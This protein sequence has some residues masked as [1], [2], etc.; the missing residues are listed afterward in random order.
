[1][2]SVTLMAAAAAALATLAGV[3]L[4]QPPAPRPSAAPSPVQR[5]EAVFKARCASCHDPAIE[6]APSR[7]DLANYLSE[8]LKKALTRGVMRDMAAGLSEADI[9]NVSWYLSG[10]QIRPVGDVSREDQNRCPASDRFSPAGP[11]WN[12]WSPD[13]VQSRHQK[14]G[15]IAAADVPKLK[16]KWAFAIEGG[17]YGQPTIFGN[18]LY[19]VSSSGRAYAL[20]AATGCVAWT[21]T[22]EF[23]MRT[24]PVVSKNRAAPSG[25]A[26]Y[27]GDY[28]KV[29]YAADAGSGKILWKLKVDPL[30][31]AVLTGGFVSNAG[32]L[33]VPLSTWE[34]AAATNGAYECC[35][36]R[37]AVIAIDEATGKQLW[38]T[39]TIAETAKPYRKNAAGTQMWGPAGA[40]IWA[41]PTLDLKR[42]LIYVATGD[43][44]TDLDDGGASDAVMA[45]DL[46]T[47]AVRWKHQ[48]TP[49]DNFISACGPSRR[50]ENCPTKVGPDVDFGASPILRTVDGKDVLLAGQ[51]SGVVYGMDPATGTVL[52]QRKVSAGS[53]GGGIIWGMAADDRTVYAAAADRQGG[54]NA[55]D[56]A[57]GELRW[58]VKID[59][60]PRCGWQGRC[61]GGYA[62]PPT[63]IPGVVLSAAADGHLRA[64]DVAT[65]QKVWDFD[66]AGQTYKTVNGVDKQRGG[67]IESYGP[68]IADGR[69]YVISGYNGAG[70]GGWSDN[71]LLAFTKDGK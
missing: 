18:R 71:V 64:F 19:V 62:S 17:R 70:G 30:P 11:S 1:V 52:W 68:T 53:A 48:V 39:Y 4:A 56:I 2:K 61:S 5:G 47:G 60:Q 26:V 7:T 49:G 15:G 23:G 12:G 8:T 3:A 40:A 32:V 44:Y 29:V 35:R 22:S 13:L 63:V 24:A 27:F 50:A 51:K 31:R 28:D 69:L 38:K 58:S 55:L 43:S 16:V 21:Y 9:D 59:P 67:P 42:N 33:Y 65:G 36:G 46:K 10:K 45:L 34:E 54:L 41:P 25:Y 20:N 6:R 14:N 66:T 57:T 37:G